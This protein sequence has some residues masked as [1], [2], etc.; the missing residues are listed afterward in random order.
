MLASLEDEHGATQAIRVAACTRRVLPG[1]TGPAAAGGQGETA[2]RGKGVQPDR[3]TAGG[4]IAHTG[5]DGDR[6]PGFSL[7][8]SY[9]IAGQRITVA[10]DGG[11]A[12]NGLAQLREHFRCIAEP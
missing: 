5:A 10:V 12:P 8:N 9:F 1:A 4:S 6:G 2:A 3:A 7:G 11:G